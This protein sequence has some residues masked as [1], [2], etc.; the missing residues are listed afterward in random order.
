MKKETENPSITRVI[1]GAKKLMI[2]ARDG[3]TL[4]FNAKEVFKSYIDSD[5]ENWGLNQSGPA[6]AETLVDVSEITRDA[7]LMQIFTGITPDLEKI[8]MTQT[9]IICFCEKYPI[10]FRQ[11]G[12]ATFFL[13]KKMAKK[14]LNIFQKIWRF[15]FDKPTGYFVVY[16]YVNSDGLE[17]RVSRLGRGSV[18]SGE[19]RHR[20][21]SLRLMPS[22]A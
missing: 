2:E 5:F 18:W 15:F 12:Y 22:I 1:S 6:T 8:V 9:Q 21:V 13:T 3:R 14:K 10:W 19:Y 20:V 11:E 16:V 7:T 4:I 17:V